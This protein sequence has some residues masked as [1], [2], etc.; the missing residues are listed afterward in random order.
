MTSIENLSN[1]LF[2][3][4]FDYLEACEIFFAFSNLNQRFHQLLN[5]SSLLL[6][7]KFNIT[8][9][10]LYNDICRQIVLL[11]QQQIFSIQLVM[12][13]HINRFFFMADD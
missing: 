12:L 1:E 4:I 10:E 11:N 9:V 5:S 3:D 8:T 13:P 7:I 6:K 2:H